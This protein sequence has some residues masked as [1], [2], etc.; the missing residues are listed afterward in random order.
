M[1]FLNY[2]SDC[3]SFDV[4]VIGEKKHTF[5][6]QCKELANTFG[7]SFRVSWVGEWFGC[8]VE[9]VALRALILSIMHLLRD[10]QE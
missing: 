3:A 5:T 9:C 8:I 10:P 4:H 7:L 1:P 6:A 2:R